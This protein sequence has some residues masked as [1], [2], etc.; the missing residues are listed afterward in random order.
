ML[1]LTGPYARSTAVAPLV[2]SRRFSRDYAQLALLPSLHRCC[3]FRIPTRTCGPL[4][5]IYCRLSVL[6]LAW[7]V[8]LLSCDI[9]SPT[10]PDS[11]RGRNCIPWLHDARRAFAFPHQ[12]LGVLAPP[13]DI[14]GP[15]LPNCRSVFGGGGGTAVVARGV[16]NFEP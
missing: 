8:L 1:A 5:F 10:I 3:S 4:A 11:A 16:R 15:P 13:P 2:A 7:L 14:A 12:P 6:A 9:S